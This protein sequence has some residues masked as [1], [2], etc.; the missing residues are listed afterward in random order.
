MDGAD[1]RSRNATRYQ[2]PNAAHDKGARGNDEH[3]WS[4]Q[5]WS[6]RSLPLCGELLLK[7]STYTRIQFYFGLGTC[8]NR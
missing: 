4:I 8:Y 6:G 3:H 1:M 5:R 7:V 2:F